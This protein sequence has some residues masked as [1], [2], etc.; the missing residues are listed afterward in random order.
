MWFVRRKTGVYFGHEDVEFRDTSYVIVAKSATLS[1]S[2]VNQMNI[3]DYNYDQ[4]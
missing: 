2:K 1:I 4:N 3:N